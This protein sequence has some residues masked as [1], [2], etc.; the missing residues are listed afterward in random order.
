ML[1]R[2]KASTMKKYVGI[3]GNGGSV[4]LEAGQSADVSDIV[5]RVLLQKYGENFEVVIEEKPAHA[6]Q[7]DKMVR[8]QPKTK[9]K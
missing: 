5:A 4:E 1:I 9:T 7:A 6:P 8:K 2:F 3:D